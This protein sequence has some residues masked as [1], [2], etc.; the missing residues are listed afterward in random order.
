VAWATILVLGATIGYAEEPTMAYWDAD[1]VSQILDRTLTIRLEPDL[2]GLSAA[3]RST[4]NDL[5]AAGRLMHEL[6]L[7]SRHREGLA[8]LESLAE[9][10][11]REQR[12]SL[13]DLFRIFKGPIAT[14]LS[15]ERQAF[16][17]VEPEVPGRN[18]YPHGLGREEIR[19]FAESR[20][21]RKA[22]LFDVRTVVR[23]ATAENL[24]S[25]RGTLAAHPVL[26]VLH[27]GLE[28]DLEML[29]ETPNPAALYAAPYSVAYADKLMQV[30]NL[31]NRAAA[32]IREE[33]GD[34]ATYLA[35]RARDLLTDDYESGDASW[36]KGRFGSLNAQIGSYE[37]YDD[38]LLGVKSFFSTSILLR[39]DERS[40]EL[41]AAIDNLQSLEN[42]LPY[43]SH[44]A[45]QS[46]IP[47]GVYN[48][49]ADFG[50][51]RGTNTA[52]IL[53]NESDHARKYGRT[54]L[55][56][57]NVMTHPDLFANTRAAWQAAVADK[58]AD[59]LVLEGGF[60]RTLWHEVGHYLGPGTTEDGQSFGV[61]LGEFSDLIE[62]LKSDLVSLHVA[63]AL[64]A[65]D[66]YDEAGL[67]A[68]YADGIR[69]TLQRVEPRRSQAYQTMQLMQMNYFFAN[70]LLKWDSS[71]GRLVIDYEQYP[72]TVEKMLREVL[73]IQL[74][75]NAELASDFIE[76]YGTWDE[77]VHGVIA[78]NISA[79]S[80]Y[81]YRLV[82]Y[83]ALG[84]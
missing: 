61:A 79:A 4:V 68:V 60:N 18:V 36:V 82:R 52:S 53:P 46:D 51:A 1:R 8:A 5:L 41:A 66:Y 30:Y 67:K 84:E 3:E 44:K 77:S 10:D 33:D 47:V 72:E 21:D 49:I 76:R 32:T 55:L 23:R 6:Y 81:R 34:F 25:D 16:L 48:V 80:K 74:S 17:P 13:L 12:E 64:L 75:G 22:S 62:E 59:D 2:S 69:R 7:E 26:A 71:A 78:N 43:E 45:V 50:Q 37:T 56:R 24:A 35:N 42:S 9:L 38:E 58:H 57:Y 14:T 27:P 28:S 29:A 31:L 63:P 11:D 39:D 65:N 15:N 83:E 73:S 19:E 54:I 70:E 40:R 20:P